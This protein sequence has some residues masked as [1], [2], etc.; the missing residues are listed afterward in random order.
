MPAHHVEQ[1]TQAA[2][3]LY[4]TV[5]LIQGCQIGLQLHMPNTTTP[6]LAPICIPAAPA[7]TVVAWHCLALA[8]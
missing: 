7:W 2:T 8:S 6:T 5:I 4:E 1:P 3:G